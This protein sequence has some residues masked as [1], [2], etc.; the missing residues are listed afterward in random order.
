MRLE[1][2]KKFEKYSD[3]LL[4]IYNAIILII[5]V[6]CSVYIVYFLF[7]DEVFTP[8]AL[9]I[10]TCAFILACLLYMIFNKIKRKFK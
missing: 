2:S 7:F 3:T 5:L 9:L 1:L 8:F 10:F 4:K 6:C